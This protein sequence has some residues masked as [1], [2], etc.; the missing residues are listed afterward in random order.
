MP[1]ARILFT[2]P[3]PE[4]FDYAVPEGM[5]IAEGSY[6]A[7]PVGKYDRLGIVVEIL[8]DAAGEGR[9]LKE[10]AEVYPVPPMTAAMR[11]F[12]SF[13]A[14][15][16]VSHPGQLLS[17]AL[18]ARGGLLPSPTETV[19]ELERPIPAGD[20]QMLGFMDVDGN[21]DPESPD[22]DEGDPVM[23]PIGGFQLRCDTQPITAEFALLLPAG[24]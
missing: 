11:D 13:S 2:L 12:L 24:R 14:R 19:Y 5:E 17:M 18:R 20:Y 22:P 16:T 23:I 1:V 3:L 21:A 8:P 10:V 9:A 4:P 6:V 7:A 15:Y